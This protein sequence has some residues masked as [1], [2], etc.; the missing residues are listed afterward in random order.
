MLIHSLKV[1]QFLYPPLERIWTKAEEVL[2]SS[3]NLTLVPGHGPDACMV[4]STTGSHPHLVKPG[5]GG[6]FMC[7]S[8]C[9]KIK[10]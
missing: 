2:L 8:D 6:C 4:K 7:D 10:H 3:D 1:S 5:K 9:L